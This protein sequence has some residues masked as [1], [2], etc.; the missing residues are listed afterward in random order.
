[1]K[2]HEYQCKKIFAAYKIPVPRGQVVASA[3]EA[4]RVAEELVGRVVVKA[5]VQVS[6]RGKAGGIRLAK[7]PSE[8]E[9]LTRMILGMEIKGL[10][11]RKVLIDEAVS[12]SRE[13]Y[14]ALVLDR[15]LGLPVLIGSPD[16]GVDIESVAHA[17]P[18]RIVRIPLD[19]LYGL[20]DYQVRELALG[21]DLPKEYWK[22]FTSI[23]KGLWAVYDQSDAVLAEINPLVIT[24]DH[25]LIAL[26]CKMTIDDNA[27][28]RH[29]D[30]NE[31]RDPDVESPMEMEAREYGL[32]FVSMPGK[33]GCMVNGAGLSMMTMD[34]I[35]AYGGEPANFLDIGGGASA[36]KAAS[37]LKIL[38]SDSHVQ[39]ILINIFGGITR[40]DEVSRGILRVY[41]PT[42]MNTPIV[43]RMVGT[44]A[45]E[46][47]K[48]LRNTGIITAEKLSEAAEK[49]VQI[50]YGVR[51]EYID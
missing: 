10:P 28:Y 20:C 14:I 35:H 49:S 23:A 18:E 27:L 47:L 19:P 33:V 11:V 22:S 5:Q 39:V 31:M 48:L 36:D 43:A 8:T 51:N 29:P 42:S 45:D 4:K 1:M 38:L 40:C 13:L 21:I 7:T 44:K 15:T 6:G 24:L 17:F 41:N 50:A 26:D 37:A 32:S 34:M 12:I 30:L 16:G 3:G 9:E 25:R 46:G 2:L